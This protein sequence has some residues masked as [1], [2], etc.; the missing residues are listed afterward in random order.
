MPP[1][2][3]TSCSPDACSRSAHAAYASCA[4]RTYDG[5]VIAQPDDPGVVL[6]RAALVPEL[7]PLQPEHAGAGA[8]RRPV[9]RAGTDAAQ[10]DDRDVELAALAH[11]GQ[12][13]VSE[14][15]WYS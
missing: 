4:N 15:S 2:L 7:E 12:T 8:L 13:S 9:R 11:A 3:M 14:C 6:R 5:R 10:A 1:V